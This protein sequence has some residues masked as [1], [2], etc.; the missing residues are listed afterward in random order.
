[1]SSLTQAV[2]ENSIQS[3][4]S[5]NVNYNHSRALELLRTGSN[6]PT[7][8]FRNGQREAIQGI[9]DGNNRMLVVQK[10]G[11][12]KSFVYFI[13]TKLL[14]EQGQ[15]PAVLI[16]P[17]LSLMRNQ[18]LA[19]TRMGVKAAHINSDN[20]DEWVS[21]E[22]LIEADNVDILI[23]SPERLANSRFR[24]KSLPQL[25]SNISLLV[26]DEAHCI[27]D[28]GHNFRPHYRLLERTIKKLPPNMRVLATTA[29]ANDRVINDLTHVLGPDIEISRGDLNR[30]SLTLQTLYIPNQAQR[31]AWIAEHLNC[32]KGSGIIYALTVRDAEELT[33]WLKHK[34]FAV[35][36]YTGQTEDRAAI[37]KNLDDNLL[38]AVV[39]TTAL[40]MGYDKPDLSFV[41]HY[42]MPGSVVAYY[43]QVGRAGRA[44]PDAYG[45]LLYGD[46]EK[47]INN[48]F[49]DNAFPS[50]ALVEKIIAVLT[51]HRDGLTVPTLM[52]FLNFGKGRIEQA[53][54]L[55]ALEFPTPIVYEKPKW[56]LN[57]LKLNPE[58]WARAENMTSLRQQE[59]QEMKSYCELPFGHHMQFL[60]RALDGNPASVV[61]PTLKP[62]SAT[63]SQQAEQDANDFL[64]RS[65][66]SI[67]PRKKWPAGVMPHYRTSGNITPA[68]QAQQGRA[69]CVWGDSGWGAQV[70]YGRYVR[71]SFGDELLDACVK[72]FKDWNPQP[73]PTWVTSIPSLRHPDLVPAFARRLACKLGLPFHEVLTKTVHRQEQKAMANSTQQALNV[74]GSM[75]L[76]TE[77]FPTGPVLLID[78][79]VNSR[80]TFTT[81]AWLL[82]KNGG[83]E[84][85]P[86]A[87]A[88]SG[89]QE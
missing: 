71:K 87:L 78:D 59:L 38:K 56:H 40:G 63:V 45:I 11:W 15:G 16:S 39:A 47:S 32:L 4:E 14:R 25:A 13:A 57:Y 85:W 79:I 82:R 52:K 41:I 10:T 60:I 42:Q 48:F 51:E 67:D 9:V 69:L 75:A 28:W 29:T 43:Q 62:F 49:I 54:N 44:L 21:I 19:A 30:A 65:N 50:P 24:E 33:R 72:M 76:V 53:L 20:E 83:G 23:I 61:A 17:L 36:A 31:M 34:G 84:V 66:I 89:H 3:K 58:F 64:C 73:A 2:K 86:L 26:V 7:A 46:E 8:Q 5:L 77:K 88:F 70:K 1:M 12:G 80:W 27:S 68:H 6:N 55:M 18:T 35:E 37:E 81:A 22:Q 74:D